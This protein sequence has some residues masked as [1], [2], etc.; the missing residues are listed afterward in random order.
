L[1]SKKTGNKAILKI[2]RAAILIAQGKIKEGIVCLEN[3]LS[4]SPKHLKNFMKLY[5]ASIKYPQVVE[6]IIKYKR[7]KGGK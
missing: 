2:Y 3:I 1:P 6:I 5:P 4:S 7:R